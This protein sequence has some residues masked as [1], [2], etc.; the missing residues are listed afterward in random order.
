MLYSYTFKNQPPILPNIQGLT[1]QE[2]YDSTF[3][4]RLG[5]ITLEEANQRFLDGNKAFVAYLHNQPAAFGWVALNKA[6]IGELNHE[7]KLPPKHGYLWNF[8][9]LVE[10]RGLGIYPHL[11][12]Y[13]LNWGQPH[14]DCLWI[15]HAPENKASEKGIRKAGFNFIGKVSVINSHEVIFT[16]ENQTLPLEDIL[17]TFGFLKSEEQQASC[18]NCSSPY[19]KNRKPQCCCASEEAECTQNVFN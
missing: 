12:H 13:I 14:M 10:F 17:D 2:N 18:W 6:R 7:F 11:L 1:I 19:L 8:R 3:M 16:H 5:Q 9:T 4:A 15:M